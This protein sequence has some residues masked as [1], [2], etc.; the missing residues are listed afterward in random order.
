MTGA[1]THG[2]IGSDRFAQY[3][4]IPTDLQQAPIEHD[5][6]ADAARDN[7]HTKHLRGLQNLA[8]E[9]SR[10]QHPA[11]QTPTAQ[12]WLAATPRSAALETA[13]RA[14][15]RDATADGVPT[16]KIERAVD[17]GRTGVYWHQQPSDPT[18][19]RLEQ[20]NAALAAAEMDA[21]A[22][23]ALLDQV[24]RF[25]LEAW[26]RKVAHDLTSTQ[27]A[28]ATAA[29]PSLASSITTD[30]TV[31]HS[32]GN[33]PST[34]GSAITDTMPDTSGAPTW[35]NETSLAPASTDRGISSQGAEL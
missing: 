4:L 29:Q 28:S 2:S 35:T 26:S 20:M 5:F 17:L 14:A 16:E 21:A 24:P 30:T 18:L 23:R 22:L 32:A 9:A 13:L 11:G 34:I 10:E 27:S 33:T 7:R 1:S 19:G 25:V 31:E 15:T 12:A 3:G 8:V 6:S